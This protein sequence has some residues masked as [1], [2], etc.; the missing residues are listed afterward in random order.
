M[1][2]DPDTLTEVMQILSAGEKAWRDGAQRECFLTYLKMAEKFQGYNDYETASYFHQRCLDTSIE[3]KY[4]EGEA[5]AHQGLGIAEEKVFNKFEAKNHLETALD[6]AKHD[7]LKEIVK[8]I[9]NDLVRVYQQIAN[10]YLDT[11]KARQTSQHH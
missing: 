7:N 5:R 2:Q 3:F 11:I 8:K 10:E 6:K 4:T 1:P 9:S